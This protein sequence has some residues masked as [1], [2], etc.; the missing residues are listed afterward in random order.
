MK[1]LLAFSTIAQLSYV[2]FGLGLSVFGSQLAFDG[3]VCHIF[4]HAFAKTL[5]FLIAG[6]FS[7]TLGTRMLPKLRGIVK[8][9]PI[10]GVGFGVAALA[11]A[12]VPPMNTF[13]SKF[14]IIAGGFS[15]GAGNVAILVLVCIM[16]AETVATFAWFLK[17]MGYCLPGEPSE[18]V[19]A[20]SPLPR[21]MAFVFIVLII[22]VIVSG[23]LSA[24]WIG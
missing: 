2:F 1:R 18:E 3:A 22:M 4:N 10:S 17:W 23:P 11:I 9:Y 6:S 15:V 8:K 24:S 20:G 19:A 7:F 14:Q 12:G 21:A 13:F 5:F 16:V